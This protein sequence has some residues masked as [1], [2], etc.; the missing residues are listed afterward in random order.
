M[1]TRFRS[2]DAWWSWGSSVCGLSTWE[3][4]AARLAGERRMA[5]RRVGC[6]SAGVG[7][8]G[9]LLGLRLSASAGAP[10]DCSGVVWVAFDSA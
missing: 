4:A 6:A 1:G 10:Q 3:A 7:G 8:G 9:E 5:A 2:A